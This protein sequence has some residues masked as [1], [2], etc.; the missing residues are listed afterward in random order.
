MR[1]IWMFLAA[2]ATPLVVSTTAFA[3]Q[4][5]KILT[6]SPAPVA[7]QHPH[8][9]ALHGKTLSDPWHWLKDE[10]YP[11]IDDAAVLD[12]VKAENAYFEAVMVANGVPREL[13]GAKAFLVYSYVI[14]DT[15]LPGDRSTLR[16]LCRAMLTGA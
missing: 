12:Y 15:L 11:V 16:D 14:T 6:N 4:K 10:S 2:I 9:V 13:A 5:E 8:E 1:T 3:E 7:Q